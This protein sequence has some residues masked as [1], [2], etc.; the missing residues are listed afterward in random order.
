V[1]E[2]NLEIHEQQ[3][4]RID[5]GARTLSGGRARLGME[6]SMYETLFPCV[7]IESCASRWNDHEVRKKAHFSR[8][9]SF[10]F[11]VSHECIEEMVATE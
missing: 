7:I 3:R 4:G 11:R 5:T 10:Y 6:M 9:N 1:D 2:C 8:F